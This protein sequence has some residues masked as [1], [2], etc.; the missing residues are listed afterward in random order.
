MPLRPIPKPKALRVGR[1]TGKFT[2]S[3][4]LDHLRSQLEAHTAGLTLEEMAALLRVSTRSV[5][6]YLRELALLTE[7][8]AVA[9]GP[10][11]ANL[12]R[13]KPSE[14]GRSVTL[15]RAQAYGILSPRRV[16]EVLRGSALFDEIDLALRQVEQVAHRPTARTGVRGDVP[17]EARLDDRFA[18]VPPLSRALGNRSEDIDAAFQAVADRATLRFRYREEGTDGKGARITSHPYALVL[19]QGSITC[20]AHDLDRAATR[21]F[22]FERMSELVAADGERFE[23]PPDFA[24]DEWLQG[25]FGIAQAPRTLRV[26]V[27]F[28]QRV[29]EAVRGR[30]VHASQRIAVA[31]DGRVR[32]SLSVPQDGRILAAVRAWV[33]SFGSAARIIE[34]REL[35][36]DVAGELRR[37]AG[38]YD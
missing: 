7:L 36:D 4:R 15:R 32:A 3:R 8:E 30:R 20:V 12:W 37:A 22:L 16:F 5:H 23:M 9:I 18:Y 28:E 10:G 31:G 35:A 24:L 13:I 2:Q 11:E 29:A 21:A 33:L 25:D 6:R 38:R 34:P 26:L 27:E 1:T 14:R 19:H 17:A